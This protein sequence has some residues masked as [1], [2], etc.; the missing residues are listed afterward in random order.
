MA[1]SLHIVCP[2]CAATN[3]VPEARLAQHPSCGQCHQPLFDGR[4][5][6]LTPDNFDAQIA[7]NDIPVV[8]DFW[9]EWCGPCKMMAP[10]FARAAGEME[11]RVRFAKL[12]TE[13]AQEIAGRYGIRSIPTMIVF[14]G[15]REV[16]RQSGAVDAASLVRW[17]TPHI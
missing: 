15:G 2:H 17:L 8:V 3:R 16:A 7:R 11:P 5:I 10:Q 6:E 12:D 9:A 13:A 14:K 1:D 4:P